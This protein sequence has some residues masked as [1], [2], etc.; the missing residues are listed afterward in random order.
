MS[1]VIDI[2]LDGS[3]DDEALV[4]DG[5]RLVVQPVGGEDRYKRLQ[6]IFWQLCQIRDELQARRDWE[7][8]VDQHLQALPRAPKRKLP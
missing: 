7:R 3:I 4:I 2:A 8:D 6:R 1:T 5:V